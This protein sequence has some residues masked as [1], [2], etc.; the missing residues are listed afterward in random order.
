LIRGAI[1][2]EGPLQTQE[3]I[4][5]IFE[6][7]PWRLRGYIG[8]EGRERLRVRAANQ[9]KA[10][11]ISPRGKN[12]ISNILSRSDAFQSM[13]GRR[14]DLTGTPLILKRNKLQ[15]SSAASHIAPSPPAIEHHSVSVTKNIQLSEINHEDD[16]WWTFFDK[17]LS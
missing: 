1:Q 2:E 17:W 13:E 4:D 9:L 15:A 3:I 10:Y 5:V 12:T 7:Q 14:W 6:Y 11:R 16:E 8:D